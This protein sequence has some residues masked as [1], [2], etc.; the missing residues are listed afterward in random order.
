MITRRNRYNQNN[1]QR[2]R[3]SKMLEKK[4]QCGKIGSIGNVRNF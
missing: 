1:R 4:I 3:F 2:R